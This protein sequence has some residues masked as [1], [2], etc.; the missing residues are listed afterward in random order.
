MKLF[1]FCI[2]LLFIIDTSFFCNIHTFLNLLLKI[3]L[4]RISNI[5]LCLTYTVALL[6][7]VIYV[8]IFVKLEKASKV[9]E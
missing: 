3:I 7:P 6:F 9:Q 4:V 2:D 1:T 8:D 5:A